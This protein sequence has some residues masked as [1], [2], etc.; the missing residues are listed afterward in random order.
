MVSGRANLGWGKRMSTSGGNPTIEVN[1][2]S[3]AWPDAPVVVVCIDGS[4]D[5]PLPH[6]PGAST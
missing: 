6:A 3:Y 2:R 5:A 1:G 4:A